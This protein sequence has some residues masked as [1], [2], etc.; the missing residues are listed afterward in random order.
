MYL[1]SCQFTSLDVE[2]PT[3]QQ[4]LIILLYKKGPAELLD[5][6]R[7]IT[8]VNKV[9]SVLAATEQLRWRL[10]AVRR[11]RAAQAEIWE[12]PRRSMMWLARLLAVVE[13]WRRL[14]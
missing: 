5:N 13:A 11:P 4:G 7:P 8:L 12:P 14:P 10:G 3:M 6:Y 1:S 2:T 9:Q